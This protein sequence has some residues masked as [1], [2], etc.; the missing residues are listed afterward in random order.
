MIRRN[1]T[2]AVNY[3]FVVINREKISGIL[4]KILENPFMVFN[5]NVR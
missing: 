1:K 3:F 5:M 4:R 2:L